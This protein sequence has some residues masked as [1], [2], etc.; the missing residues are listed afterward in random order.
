[1][2]KMTCEVYLSTK[3]DV[4]LIVS[5]TSR[6]CQEWVIVRTFQDT[7]DMLVPQFRCSAITKQRFVQFPHFIITQRCIT[8]F[9]RF[10]W[11]CKHVLVNICVQEC[12]VY[13]DRNRVGARRVEAPKG[14][15]PKIPRFFFRRGFTRE[16][17]SPN[18][19]IPGPRPSKT[20]QKFN[21][22]TSKRGRKKER[23]KKKREILGFPFGTPLFG[24]ALFPSLGL[25][26]WSLHP[27]GP[28]PWGP[29][30]CISHRVLGPANFGQ[31]QFWANPFL[32]QIGVLVVWPRRVGA[33]KGGPRRVGGPE[34]FCAFFPSPAPFSLFLFVSGCLLVV[35]WWCLKRRGSQMSTFGVL[36]LSCEAPAASG[37]P[38]FHT[39]TREPKRTHFRVPVFTNTTKI[40]REDTQ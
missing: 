10:W 21:E 3:V 26:P 9:V 37:P 25:H 11:L 23:G 24:A 22:R 32:A 18:V 20:P 6:I 8:P 12:C 4:Q 34:G 38:G 16:P 13:V 5:E 35:F 14:G 1:M 36:G 39:T 17:E 29:H 7:E 40:Q 2:R 28:H 33:P 15:G 31:I 19:H 27:S 30:F